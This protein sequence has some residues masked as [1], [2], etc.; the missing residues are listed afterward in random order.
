M[1]G[2]S[3]I[4][5]NDKITARDRF[6]S[7]THHIE[8]RPIRRLSKRWR[9]VILR[10]HIPGPGTRTKRT[11]VDLVYSGV[12]LIS[13]PGI[14]A[15][16]SG[17]RLRYRRRALFNIQGQVNVIPIG[18]IGHRCEEG[19]G[20]VDRTSYYPRSSARLRPHM[21]VSRRIGTRIHVRPAVPRRRR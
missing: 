11:V 5:N 21:Q 10:L 14:R 12:V 9:A 13:K 16:Y 3:I 17:H 7:S 15:H 8:V 4:R 1:R 20:G 18:I 6:M 2:R 19:E